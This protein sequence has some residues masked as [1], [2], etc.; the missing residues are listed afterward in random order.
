MLQQM[1]KDQPAGPA[2]AV[3]RIVLED[4]PYNFSARTRARDQA[5]IIAHTRELVDAAL[6]RSDRT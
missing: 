1:V 4:G 6:S 5:A 3:R 2:P